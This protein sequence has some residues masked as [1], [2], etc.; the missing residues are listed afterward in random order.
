MNDVIVLGSGLGGLIAGTFLAKRDFSV[1]LLKESGYR[2]FYENKGFRFFP[3]SNFSE[4]HPDLVLLNKLSQGLDLSLSRL[5]GKGKDSPER[6][7]QVPF[8]VILP[9]GRIDISSGRERFRLELEREFPDEV[10]EIE[11]FYDEID[12]LCQL[13]RE[14]ETREGPSKFFLLRTPSAVKRLFSMDPFKGR[15]GKRVS[16]FSR[17]FKTFIN[18]QLISQGNLFSN[19]FSME[20]V[21]HLLSRR[22]TNDQT[23]ELT[24]RVGLESVRET[25]LKD[26][27]QSGGCVEEIETMEGFEA[28]RGRGFILS[29]GDRGVFHC[30]FL[31]L[32]SPLQ[33]LSNL[34]GSRETRVIRLA[35]RIQPRCLILPLFLGIR[36]KGVPVGM[37]DLLVSL[38]DLERPFEGGNLLF[39]A[40]SPRGDE[41]Q[42]PEGRRALIAESLLSPGK[43]DLHS[44]KDHQKGVMDHLLW[45]FP[46][47][48]D[49]I[50]CADWG[51]GE[52]QM[53]RW[54][55][56]YFFY[57]TGSRFHWREGV[58]PTR[59]SKNLYLVGKENFPHLGLEGETLSGLMVG[60]QIQEERS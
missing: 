12:R 56:P 60:Q 13:E 51:W 19:R 18:L 22:G 40:L 30:R 21:A 57:E 54:S 27:S 43:K 34:L 38:F 1:L 33:G 45:L 48:E 47:L 35:Q 4:R 9:K 14:A 50:E 55:Y 17:E 20:A 10:A 3:F 2:P 42:A 11:S 32:N 53:T 15:L 7:Q 37:K 6:E 36:E 8:Q 52:E 23:G 24:S 59:I 31:I 28:K 5:V 58:I 39:L 44:T 29:A 16:L 41:T 46:F 26:F 25:I 49:H